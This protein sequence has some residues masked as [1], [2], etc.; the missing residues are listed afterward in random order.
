MVAPAKSFLKLLTNPA[1][2]TNSNGWIECEV[3]PADNL[4]GDNAED[5]GVMAKYI[6]G[7]LGKRVTV[8][9]T[10]AR[11][12]SHTFD[13]KV[14]GLL[15]DGDLGKTEIHPVT[16][17]LVEWPA[18][19]DNRERLIDFFVFSDDSANVPAHV[20]HS[21]ENRE[22]G[23]AIPIPAG[24]TFRLLRELD[25][26]R[27][28][29]YTIVPAPTHSTLTASVLSG[30]ASEGKGFYYARLALPGYT[31]RTFLIGRGLRP[32]LGVRAMMSEES[33]F[34]MKSLF[35]T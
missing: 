32:D 27:S 31:L 16:S 17:L 4:G 28:K 15:D 24:T 14:I 8:V 34:S 12:R 25:M 7:I 11:D 29:T 6:G 23:F 19:A 10:W 9:G 18:G 21:D 5:P 2:K 22:G 35:T 26:A 13:D 33:V 20:P 30:R 3:E 1:G